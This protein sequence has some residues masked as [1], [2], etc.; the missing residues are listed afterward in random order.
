MYLLF[1]NKVVNESLVKFRRRLPFVQ[2][3]IL[4]CAKR[5]TKF[6]KIMSLLQAIVYN[7]KFMLAMI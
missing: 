7:A 5:A 2:C 4:K 1:I 3:N 6:Y